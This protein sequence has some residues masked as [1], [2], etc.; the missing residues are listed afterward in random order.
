MKIL[1]LMSSLRSGSRMV[2]SMLREDAGIVD[3]GGEH[4]M[5]TPADVV[6]LA[7]R[8]LTSLVALKYGVLAPTG[9]CLALADTAEACA[10]VLH[11]RDAAAQ[12][13]S[14]AHARRHGSWFGH[15]YD[16]SPVVV[17]AAEAA[18]LAVRNRRD[19]DAILAALTIPHAVLAYEDISPATLTAALAPLLGRPVTV[20]APATLKIAPEDVPHG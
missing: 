15:V 6:A 2:R 12:A 5:L 3:L 11:R 16:S 19:R 14:L 1:L 4:R 9:D 17:D 10:L 20:V 13:R 7:V 8:P 18:A